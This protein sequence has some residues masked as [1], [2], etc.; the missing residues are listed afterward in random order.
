[1]NKNYSLNMSII[2]SELK[3]LLEIMKMKN[4]DSKWSLKKEL[5][6]DID[7]NLFVILVDHHRVYPLIYL[8]IKNINNNMIPSQVIQILQKKY[9]ENT[10][11]MLLLSAEMENI[12]KDFTEKNIR[13]LFLKGPVIAED[14]YGDISL[15]TSK[16]LDILVPINDISIAEKLLLDRGYKSEKSI[17]S[18]ENWRWMTH[19]VTYYHPQKKVQIEI[20]WRLHPPPGKEPSFNDLWKRKR[21]SALTTYQVHFLG[22]EDLF[23]YLVSHGARHGWFRLRW[24]VDIDKIIR[25]RIDDKENINVLLKE[26]LN[27]NYIAQ[28]IVLANKLLNTPIPEEM[29]SILTVKHT[30]KK[31]QLSILYLVKMGNLEINQYNASYSLIKLKLQRSFINRYLFAMKSS[32]HKIYFILKLFYPSHEDSV[33]LKLPKSLY[34]LYFPLRPFLWAWRK[35]RK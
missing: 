21:V 27:Y 34:F 15:R 9:K 17:V 29:K 22:K 20:H 18:L 28:T 14:I 23:T 32:S 6:K 3:L 13:L 4:D 2:S 31:A 1:M 10:F 30:S 5:V 24:L 26:Y 7:W 35:A 12:S 33:T 11:Q 25:K 19:H 8:K 16:D